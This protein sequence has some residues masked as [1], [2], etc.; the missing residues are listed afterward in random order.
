M[1]QIIGI[2]DWYVFPAISVGVTAERLMSQ[3]FWGRP[4]DEANIAAALPQARICIRELERLQGAA[5]FLAGSQVSIADLML[6][7]HL[8]YFRATP[9]GTELLQ[10]TPLESWL[11]RMS[12]R[13]SMQATQAERLRKIA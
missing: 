5:E 13:A 3:A 6:V 8:E 1:N 7:P 11:T 2:V 9:E 4:A 12:L 10:G